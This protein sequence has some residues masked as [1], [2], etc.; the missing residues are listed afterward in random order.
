MHI[1]MLTKTIVTACSE[2]DET[3]SASV[4]SNKYY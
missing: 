3:A 4:N 2:I 1:L